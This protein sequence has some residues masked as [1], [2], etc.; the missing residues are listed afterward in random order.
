MRGF[1]TAGALAA[2]CA[3]A[4][5]CA[6][7]TGAE[8]DDA[9]ANLPFI[10]VPEIDLDPYSGTTLG[11]IPTV[12][13]TNAQSEIEEIIAPDIIHNQ[14]FGWGSR[15][16]VFGY[17]SADEQWMVVGGGKERVEREFDG[18][19]ASGQAR[20]GLLTWSV[21]AIYD[22]SGTPRFF[23]LGNGAPF[24][25]QT[26]YLDNQ[27][28]LDGRIGINFSP[29]LQ[30]AYLARGRYVDVLPGVLPGVPSI[31][32]LFPTQP[33]VG[34]EHELQQRLTF[35]YD[36][37]DSLLI[38]RSGERLL[39]YAGVVTRALGSSVSY[40]IAGAEARGYR[41]L[42]SDVTLVWHAALRYMPSARG[43]PFW[44]LSS[45]GGDISVPGEREPLRSDG[46]DRYLDRN[47]SAA[48]GELRTR[49]AS[50]DALGTRIELEL[51][52]FVDTGKVFSDPGTSPVSH[53]HHAAGIGVR[54]IASP[55]VVG[56]V[57]FGY[58]QGR[59]AVFSGI[60]YPF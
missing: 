57:D 32:T 40:S 30:L 17:P 23:G 44:S 51:A 48:G 9:F 29:S 12:L 54:G 26:S 59:G 8:E 50:F 56:Y 15:M 31:T 2:M 58:G 14:Y 25:N 6:A 60:D 11:L 35:T 13:R 49:V 33:G 43:A 52:P 3:V 37:R 5:V 4:F 42:G 24:A 1:E 18:R 22:R 45:L 53:L 10:P 19:F 20:L 16:R 36:T 47:L 7:A 27:A 39:I 41:S 28:S 55:H 21:E 38:P 46:S 34:A